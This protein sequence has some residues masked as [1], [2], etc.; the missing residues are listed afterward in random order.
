[1]GPVVGF[2]AGAATLGGALAIYRLAKSGTSVQETLDR[3][4]RKAED[5]ASGHVDLKE[6]KT[7]IDYK[8]D[9]DGIYRR[10]N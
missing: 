8:R 2:L 7:V 1:M 9:D 6:S 4:K 10:K 5:A 3:L